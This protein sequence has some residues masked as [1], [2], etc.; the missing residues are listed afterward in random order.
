MRT[1]TSYVSHRPPEQREIEERHRRKFHF[2]GDWQTHPRMLDSVN[3]KFV[4][5]REGRPAIQSTASSHN[6]SNRTVLPTSDS[7]LTATRVVFAAW[8]ATCRLG[9]VELHNAMTNGGI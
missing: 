5:L 1:R 7:L 2:V 6:G 3:P 8:I 9:R 4:S